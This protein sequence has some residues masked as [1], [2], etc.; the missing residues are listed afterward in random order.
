[1]VSLFVSNGNA[2]GLLNWVIIYVIDN[3]IDWKE[4]NGMPG[5]N[6]ERKS[7]QFFYLCLAL[8]EPKE[9]HHQQIILGG[10]LEPTVYMGV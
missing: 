7:R 9:K 8:A 5:K 10:I 2:N 4:V 3:G 1:M 6:L